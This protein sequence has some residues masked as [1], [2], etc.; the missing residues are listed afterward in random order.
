[1]NIAGVVV[2]YEP[3]CYVAENIN[4][5][6]EYVSKLYVVDNSERESIKTLNA[7]KLIEKIEYI[8]LGGNKGIARALNIGL[9]KAIEDNFDYLLTMDQDSKFGKGV[10]ECYFKQCE[11]IFMNEPKV[12]L[13]G[14]NRIGLKKYFEEKEVVD[15]DETITS[16]M[17]LDVKKAKNVGMFLEKLFI[18]YVDYE[19]CYRAKKYGY[20][21]KLVTNCLLTHQV[22]NMNPIKAFGRTFKTHN[23]H[24]KVRI[25]YLTRNA[26]YTIYL[27]PYTFWRIWMWT[28]KTLIK[29]LLVDDDKKEKLLYSIYGIRDFIQGKSG[30]YK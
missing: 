21:C 19:F 28:I 4:T 24:N 1:M 9:K 22:G 30:S 15:V 2:L 25:Y 6:L 16:G 13:S 5:Y 26:L 10:I 17:V 29:I 27:Y 3:D 23:E 18:D 20:C 8:F 11:K 12:I 7:I 14:I